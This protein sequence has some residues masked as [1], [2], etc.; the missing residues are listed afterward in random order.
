MLQFESLWDM[1]E[2]ERE[3]FDILVSK[4]LQCQEDGSACRKKP[5]SNYKKIYRYTKMLVK[6]IGTGILLQ[7]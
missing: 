5:R 4:A 6:L 3:G 7:H 1:A 2:P